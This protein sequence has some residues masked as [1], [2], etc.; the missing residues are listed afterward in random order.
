ETSKLLELFKSIDTELQSLNEASRLPVLIGELKNALLNHLIPIVQRVNN[1]T[2]NQ[3]SPP[4]TPPAS[5][6]PTYASIVQGTSPTEKPIPLKERRE[7]RIQAGDL[8]A[9]SS[10]WTPTDI[11]KAVN[12]RLAGMGLGKIL[13]TR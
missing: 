13:N 11:T 10:A 6:P 5:P 1:A 12:D 2:K 9:E 3:E 7:I 4:K 8:T